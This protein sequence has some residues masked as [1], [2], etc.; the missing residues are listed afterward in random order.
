MTIKIITVVKDDLLG[1]KRT[2]RSISGQSKRVSWIVVTPDDGSVTFDYVKGLSRQGIVEEII[3]DTHVGIYPAMN[4]AIASS[5]GQDWLWFLNAGDELANVNS[6]ELVQK[7][8]QSSNNAWMYGG[9]ILSSPSGNIIGRVKPPQKFKPSNQLFAKNIISHQ[10]TIFLAKFLQ[11]LGGF[12]SNLKIAADWDLMVRAS[13][14][15][16]GLR[17]PESLSIFYMGGA[18]TVNRQIGNYELFQ[19]RKIHLGS[20]YAIKNYW[21]FGYRMLRNYCIRSIEKKFPRFLDYVRK[22]RH[23]FKLQTVSRLLSRD[24]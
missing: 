16:P 12:K 19:I 2:E 5:T 11:D 17:I 10:S 13:E 7:Y 3:L 24:L 14:L 8:G 6:Y 23:K 1:L 9:Y 21:W 18:S 20:K 4:Q 15:G 22:V